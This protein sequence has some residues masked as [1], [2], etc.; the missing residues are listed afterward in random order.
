M[1]KIIGTSHIAKQ[2][3]ENIKKEFKDFDP[4]IVAIELDRP[5]MI[6]LLSGKKQ[7]P[8]LRD[9]FKIGFKGYVFLLIGAWAEKRLG[10]AVGMK[11]GVDMLTAVKL[12]KKEKRRIALIDQDIQITLRKLSKGISWKEK[13][14]FGVD[15]FKAVILGKREV[16]FDLRTVPDDKLIGK[17][18]DKVRDRYPN[19]Y[20]VLVTE[21][22]EFMARKLKHLTRS[23]PDQKILAVVGAGHKEEMETLINTKPGISFS[24]SIDSNIYS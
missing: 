10:D 23:Y 1:L 9:A 5:R 20:R 14:N 11:P 16:D 6:S 3:V 2:S 8:R 4:D 17:M 21:R 12:A 13:W 7:R 24:Y 22:N 18:I 19:I 15:L